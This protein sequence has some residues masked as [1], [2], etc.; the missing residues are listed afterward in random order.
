LL[1][2]V[3]PRGWENSMR[4]P[5][6]AAVVVSTALVGAT[7]LLRADESLKA[8]GRQLAQECTPCHRLDGVD[9]GIPSIVGLKPD[10]FIKIMSLYK[11]GQRNNPA[12]VSVAQSLDDQQIKAL[13]LY[14]GALPKTEPPGGTGKKTN[15]R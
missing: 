3:G 13:A 7:E 5:F 15:K 11:N 12:M 8:V 10:D 6:V 4:S 9:A 14:L 2:D 1:I